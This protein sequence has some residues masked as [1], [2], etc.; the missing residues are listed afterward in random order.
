MF[1]FVCGQNLRLDVADAQFT[2]HGSGGCLAVAADQPAFNAGA[3]KLID[4]GPRAGLQGVGK[5]H[6]RDHSGLTIIDTEPGDS[7]PLGFVLL[8]RLFP[9]GEID[10]LFAHQQGIAEPGLV[11]INK[12]AGA[13]SG[14]HAEILGGRCFDVPLEGVVEQR[15]SQWML[16]MFL[17]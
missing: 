3:G 11:P 1:G 17:D 13:T 16:G 5:G 10:S 2:A 4:G 14:V 8:D 15:C 9:R 7:A 6:E 12:A